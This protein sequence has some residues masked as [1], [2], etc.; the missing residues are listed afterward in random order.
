MNNIITD[1]LYTSQ[2]V[3]YEASRQVAG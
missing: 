2:V 1:V 3:P